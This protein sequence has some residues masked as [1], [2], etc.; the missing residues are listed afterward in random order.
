MYKTNCIQN[1][2]CAKQTVYKTKCIQNKVC[3][4]QTV[5]KTKCVQNKLYTK[6]SVHK[7]NKKSLKLQKEK[8]KSNFIVTMC[9]LDWSL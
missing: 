7:I 2:V 4:K 5:Y 9:N 1:K 6:H 3:A 8:I